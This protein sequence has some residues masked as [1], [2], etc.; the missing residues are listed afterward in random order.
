MVAMLQEG[1]L[2]TDRRHLKGPGL[3]TGSSSRQPPRNQL[4]ESTSIGDSK[5]TEASTNMSMDELCGID[6]APSTSRAVEVTL[7]LQLFLTAIV[8][9]NTRMR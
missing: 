6:S 3:A 8:E 2:G 7:C 5:S 1:L 9:V 4:M